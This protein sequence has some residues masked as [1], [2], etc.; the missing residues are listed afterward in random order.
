MKNKQAYLTPLTGSISSR[1][2]AMF[3]SN[4]YFFSIIIFTNARKTLERD[5]KGQRRQRF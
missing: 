4:M 1:N 3:I 2:S 5:I